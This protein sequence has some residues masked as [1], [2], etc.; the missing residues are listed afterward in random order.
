MT[1]K[2]ALNKLFNEANKLSREEPKYTTHDLWEMV[3]QIEKDLEVLEILKRNLYV[4]KGT[5]KFKGI[6][7][8]QC[9]LGNQHSEDNFK[10]VKE[11]L[12]ND[13]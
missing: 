8:I 13:K 7:I 11:W 6:E 4:E 5:G 10:K 3:N 2:E 9:S 12:E 1:S